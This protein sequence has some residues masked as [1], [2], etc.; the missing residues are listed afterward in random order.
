MFY[1]PAS[2]IWNYY[3]QPVDIIKLASNNHLEDD[4]Q[5]A[6]FQWAKHY[7]K[8]KWMHSIPNGAFLAG[9]KL[10]RAKQMN[11]LKA[12]GL[13]PGI[14]DIFLPMITHEWPGLYI[15]MKAGKNK[16]TEQQSEFKVY[17]EEQGYKCEVCYSSEEAINVIKEYAYI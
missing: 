5:K 1:I 9:N 14:L 3:F 2:L 10:Q 13:T 7:P 11:R 16:L 15:E 4:A 12:Q 17:A 8:L 6:V